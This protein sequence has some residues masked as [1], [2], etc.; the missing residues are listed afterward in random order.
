MQSDA[1]PV[2]HDHL[3]KRRWPVR[4]M[5]WFAYRMLRAGVALTGKASEY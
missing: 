2:T 4:L 5:D 1:V 3:K